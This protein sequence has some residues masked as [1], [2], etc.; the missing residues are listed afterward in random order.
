LQQAAHGLAGG[1]IHLGD[2]LRLPRIGA[3][4]QVRRHQVPHQR[5]ELVQR[6]SRPLR[7]ARVP[8]SS[9]RSSRL[10]FGGRPGGG[11]C[12]GFRRAQSCG[13]GRECR[14]V[15]QLLA[16][17]AQRLEQLHPLENAVGMEVLQLAES[18]RDLGRQPQF[19][20]QPL[21]H[22]LEV[23]AGPPEWGGARRAWLADTAV[24]PVR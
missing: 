19:R 15:A 8:V 3:R 7:L 4:H 6:A 13:G 2:V 18:Q 5:L 24:S 14:A 11:R 20:Q 22:L 1:R 10:N 9:T 21:E 16:R 23:V 17:L 12:G